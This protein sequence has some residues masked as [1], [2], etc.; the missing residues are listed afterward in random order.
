MGSVE[1]DY[2]S[3]AK[4]TRPRIAPRQ[5][6]AIGIVVAVVLLALAVAVPVRKNMRYKALLKEYFRVAPTGIADVEREYNLLAGLDD[7]AVAV[8]VA[9]TGNANAALARLTRAKAIRREMQMLGYQPPA[10]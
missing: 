7:K 2:R 3:P 6:W 8:G 9:P 1:I 10:D 5:A 4:R